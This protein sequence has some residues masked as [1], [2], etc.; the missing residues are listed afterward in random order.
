M[1]EFLEHKRVLFMKIIYT[2]SKAA[3]STFLK[4]T[5]KN[6]IDSLAASQIQEISWN[7]HRAI[8]TNVYCLKYLGID[9][10]CLFLSV[11]M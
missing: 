8:S 6:D 7:K 11:F 2:S 5:V 9:A 1:A 3:N 4:E 10:F